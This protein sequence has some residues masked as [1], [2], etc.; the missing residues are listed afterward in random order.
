MPRL[1]SNIGEIRPREINSSGERLIDAGH[2]AQQRRL[3]GAVVTDQRYP[4]ARQ[5]ETTKDV[6]QSFDD[7]AVV[8]ITGKLAAGS[9][10]Q[11]SLL[12]GARCRYDRSEMI[13]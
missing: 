13:R 8:G 7:D 4:I 12:Q 5:T 3:S 2:H 9:A 6:A 10:K 11:Q 1:M